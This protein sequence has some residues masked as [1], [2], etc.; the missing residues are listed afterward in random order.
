M[1]VGLVVASSMSTIDVATEIINSQVRDIFENAWTNLVVCTSL[2][3]YRI[4]IWGSTIQEHIANP[5]DLDII[6][7]YKTSESLTT[8]KEKSIEGIVK[9]NTYV[10]QFDLIDP[11]VTHYEKTESIIANSRVSKAYDISEQSYD[12][13]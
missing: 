3:E 8:Q 13:F 5:D 11:L 7:E 12:T 10:E 4:L 1:P 2:P 9:S 6:I